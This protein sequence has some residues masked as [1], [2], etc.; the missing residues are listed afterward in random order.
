MIFGRQPVA[1]TAVIRALVVLGTAFGLNL[2]P[3]QIAAVYL[4]A[5]VILSFVAGSA[6]TPTAAPTLPIGTPVSTPDGQP[7]GVVTPA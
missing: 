3:Q 2:E 7:D 4:A 5:E 1:W 6:S